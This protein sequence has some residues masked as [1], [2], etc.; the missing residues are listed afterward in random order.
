MKKIE[1]L[2]L[3]LLPICL[4]I[5]IFFLPFAVWSF[6]LSNNW[7]FE[8]GLLI[9]RDIIYHHPPLPLFTL[10]GASKILGNNVWMLRIVSYFLALGFCY[11]LYF[12]AKYIKKSVSVIALF[13]LIITFF[14]I[15][16]NFNFEEMMA[17][18]LSVLAMVFFFHYRKTKAAKFLVATGACIGAAIMSKQIA[19]GAMPAILAVV[20]YDNW[21]NKP[22][23]MLLNIIKPVLFLTVGVLTL[24]I[25]F[26]F[27]FYLHGALNDFLYWNF[28]YNFTVYPKAYTQY[29][30][31]IDWREAILNS[32][33]IL[34]TIISGIILLFSK[35][36]PKETR[37]NNLFLLV[38][39]LAFLPAL[40]PSFNTYKLINL[41]PYSLLL[42]ALVFTSLTYIKRYLFIIII[43]VSITVPLKVFYV[44]FFLA[45]FP[46]TEFINEYGKDA[47]G[48]MGWLMDNAHA[49]EKI[50]NLGEPYI[51]TK[52]HLLPHNKYLV[53]FPWLLLPFSKSSSEILAHP[54]RIIIVDNAQIEQFP[55]LN[56]WQFLQSVKK[57]Y[58][59]AAK[60]GT[61]EIFI[62][63]YTRKLP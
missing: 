32:L 8:N 44:D 19:I 39:I 2:L 6:P 25:P 42:F 1:T 29:S 50:V 13:L 51:T 22:K 18:F 55:I 48:V 57:R 40:L 27:Y 59:R 36:V 62:S 10:L 5:G 12:L 14:P 37:K 20:I 58:R 11:S 21:K 53:S 28:V 34:T 16:S 4:F 46:S 33:W 41:Y 24:V 52:S 15:A 63:A 7:F 9:Y 23:A 49:K 54:P 30:P 47:E 35:K 38:S 60:F 56:E 43:L 26:I 61:Y 45:Y 17:S 31:R 3:F